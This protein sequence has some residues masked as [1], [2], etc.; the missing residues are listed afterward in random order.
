MLPGF[1]PDALP[2]AAR[3]ALSLLL[4]YLVSFAIQIQSPSTAGICVA[5]IA[6]PSAGMAFSKAAYRVLGTVLGGVAAL[7]LIEAFPQDRTMLLAGYALWLGLCAFVAALL[8]DFRSYGAAL[9]GYTAG[10]IAIA[11]IDAPETALIVALD[12]VAAIL[13]GVLSVLV[14]N[15]A[16]AGA[17]AFEALVKA[18]HE[19]NTRITALAVDALEERPAP[20]DLTLIRD[21]NGVTALQTQ[22][23]YAAAE[24]PDGQVR[25]NGARHV[26]AALLATL[27]ISR[28]ISRTEARDASPATRTHLEAVAAALRGGPTPPPAPPPTHPIDALLLECAD[29]LIDFRAKASAGLRTLS[30]GA[31]LLPRISVAVS[32]DI[33]GALLGA[34]RTIIAIGLCATFTVLAG[35]SGATLVLIQS[36]AIIALLGTMPNPSKASVPF[37]FPILPMALLVG[38]AKFVALA[39]ASGFVPFALTIGPLAFAVALMVRQP[40]LA[41]YAPPTLLFLTL[42]LSPANPQTFDLTSFCNTVLEVCLALLFVLLAFRLILPMSPTRSLYRVAAQIGRNLRWTLRNDRR[43][44]QRGPALSVLYDRMSRA[45]LWLGR[46]TP[47]RQRL[48]SHLYGMGEM[49]IA[50]RRA[51]TGL[52]ATAA[53]EP[54]LSEAVAVAR[55]SLQK[56][57]AASIL[58]SAQELLDGQA[59][60]LAVRQA[61]SG[62]AAA[63]LLLQRDPGLLRFYRRF[64][65]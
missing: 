18:L 47:A 53:L 5:L 45:L 12:R 15:N 16:F 42:F 63:A 20:D 62:M 24:L 43:R 32:Y 51:R 64:V 28:A 46:P 9:S 48:L 38:F 37:L 35:W 8:R 14:V 52:A 2:F 30:E 7:L 22:A 59:G 13:I 1:L 21:A 34:L 58:Q 31:G 61:V 39:A 49:D 65:S 33:P 19:R 54:A 60:S 57:D 25:S 41:P 10:V 29:D 11:A 3:T 40:R 55:R 27:S 56:S 36:S 4:A 17:G 50:V 26:I 23:V 44:F 6:Q